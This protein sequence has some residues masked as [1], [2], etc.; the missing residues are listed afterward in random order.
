[1]RQM[2]EWVQK[3]V[4]PSI[5]GT[6][7]AAAT[8]VVRTLWGRQKSQE[9][10]QKNLRAGMMALLHDSIYREC[11]EC[12]KKKCATADDLKN[13]ECLYEPYHALGGNGTG[14]VLYERV[15]KLPAEPPQTATA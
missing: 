4:I 7:M 11:G 15:K 13:L 8:W 5:L 6:I 1:M 9:Q 14:T 2:P 3:Y 10:E 12:E